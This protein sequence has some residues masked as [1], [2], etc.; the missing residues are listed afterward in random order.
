MVLVYIDQCVIKGTGSR[1]L[2][3]VKVVSL[4]TS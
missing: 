2:F 1:D 3:I 4:E